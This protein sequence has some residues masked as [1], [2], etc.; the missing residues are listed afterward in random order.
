M[1]WIITRGAKPFIFYI[2]PLLYIYVIEKKEIHA[3]SRSNEIVY[4]RILILRG[5]Q[6]KLKLK[7]QFEHKVCLTTSGT[8]SR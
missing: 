3:N 4:F 8:K 2:S 5:A 7:S 6:K 1:E